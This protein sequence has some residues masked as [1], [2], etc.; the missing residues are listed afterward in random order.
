MKTVDL[1]REQIKQSHEWFAQ[2]AADV[3]PE[4]AHWIPPGIANPLGAIYAHAIAAEDVIVN[5][6]LKGGQPLYATAFAGRSGISE[7]QLRA[8]FEWA[9]RV[10]VDLPALREYTQA[11]WAAT[12]AYIAS[13]TDADLDRIVE[14]TL[15]KLPV[16]WILSNLVL[17]H[18]HNMMGEV[19]VLKGVQGA[20]GY[21][22]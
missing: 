1:L 9:R 4:Q 20:K 17:A 18:V 11:V 3:T 13:L 5:A 16:S 12:D 6:V 2:T 7:P 19:S 10:K 8:E 15:G 21:P 22:F 14:T